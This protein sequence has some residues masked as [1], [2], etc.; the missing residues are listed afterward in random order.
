MR[1]NRKLTALA[2]ISAAAL[3]VTAIGSTQAHAADYKIT[4]IQGV[5][6]DA[7]Y[8][9]MGCGVAAAAAKDGATITTQGGAKW[10][11]TIQMPVLDSVIA[12]K[13]DAILI[14]PND[15]TALQ[16]PIEAA[17][18]AGIKVVLVDTT[19]DNAAPAVAEIAS[20]N[21]G[22]GAAAFAAVK[23]L[24][25]KGGKVL[26][27]STSPGVSS[28]DARVNGFADAANKDKKF[29]YIGVQYSNNEPAIAQRIVTAALSKNKDIVAVFA[30]NLFSAQ[31]VAAG[32]KQ[33]G[34]AGKVKIVGFDAG[35]DQVKALKTGVVQALIAQQPATIGSKGVDAAVAALQGKTVSPHKVQTGFTILTM[36]NINTAAGLAAQYR[37]KC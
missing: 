20:D 26:V 9:T 19:V 24:A 15:K 33:A 18:A 10:D 16:K 30:T 17:I 27:V 37:D 35:S 7:F 1:K 11:A 29:N 6:G 28:V 2:A 32:I 4:F 23:Q 12:S 5:A 14:A 22:G 8:V 25:P 36:K 21:Y 31:G 3:A 13:P 34:K